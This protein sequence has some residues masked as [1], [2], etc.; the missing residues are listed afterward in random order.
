MMGIGAF[1]EV[2]EYVGFDVLGY[3]SGFLEYGAGDSSPVGGPWENASLD[4]LAN[5]LGIIIGAGG[6]LFFKKENS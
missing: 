4:M 5:L 3:G 1:N 2:L 6:F